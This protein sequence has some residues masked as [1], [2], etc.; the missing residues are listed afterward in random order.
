MPRLE[1]Y[2]NLLINQFSK[3]Y[4]FS[5]LGEMLIGKFDYPTSRFSKWSPLF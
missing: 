1:L 3:I 2:K 4:Y 5:K